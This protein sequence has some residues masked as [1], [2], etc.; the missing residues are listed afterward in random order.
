M[1]HIVKTK[2][3]RGE[4]W[5]FSEYIYFTSRNFDGSST[6]LKQVDDD[7]EVILKPV[8]VTRPIPWWHNTDVDKAF[9]VLC[10][11]YLPDKSPHPTND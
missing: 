3:M 9:L 4:R 7:D 5:L 10:E 1:V 8:Y 11:T 2:I 6:G